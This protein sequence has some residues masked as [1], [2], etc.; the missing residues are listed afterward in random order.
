MSPQPKI[1]LP[2]HPGRVRIR[3]LAALAMALAAIAPA[4]ARAADADVPGQSVAQGEV[5][6]EVGNTGA[7]TGPHVHFETRLDGAAVDPMGYL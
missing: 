6:G 2:A 4:L 1:P 7:S 3:V 5:I